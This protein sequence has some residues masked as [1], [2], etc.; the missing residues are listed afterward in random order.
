MKQLKMRQMTDETVEDVTD[1]RWNSWLCDRWQMKKLTMRQMT[2]EK[3]DHATDDRWKSWRCDRWQMKEK[4][5][6]ATDNRW[7]KLTM[8][9]DRWKSWRCDRWQMK[10]LKMWQSNYI[11]TPLPLLS[12]PWI[13]ILFRLWIVALEND[14]C[15]HSFL[16]LYYGLKA[17]LIKEIARGP[18]LFPVVFIA[19]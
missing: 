6:H 10:K 11:L 5:D 16:V 8:R 15:K 4:V 1:D 12:V 3:V 14:Y 19:S 9:H 17:W 18:R 13:I 2:D 7:K